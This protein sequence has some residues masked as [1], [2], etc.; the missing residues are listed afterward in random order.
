MLTLEQQIERV[1][2]AAVAEAN[3]PVRAKPDSVS[4]LRQRGARRGVGLAA[5]LLVLSML[6]ALT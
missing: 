4:S 3:Q 5:G 1:A 2:D 6:G